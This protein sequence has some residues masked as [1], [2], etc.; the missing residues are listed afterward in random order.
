MCIDT[1]FSLPENNLRK[2]KD[3]LVTEFEAEHEKYISNVKDTKT[4]NE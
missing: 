1:I 3:E 4:S 2:S